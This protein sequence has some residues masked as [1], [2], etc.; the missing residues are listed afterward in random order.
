MLASGG[1][2]AGRRTFAAHLRG[3]GLGFAAG[4]AAGVA[5]F[6]LA[7]V[8]VLLGDQALT[9]GDG[10]LIVVGVNFAE[11]QE[12]MTV[13]AVID[14]CGLQRRFDANDFGEVDVAFDLLLCR[15][16]YIKFLKARSVQHHHASFLCVC[17]IDQHSLDHSK[18]YSVAPRT[19]RTSR[20]YV[21]RAWRGGKLKGIKGGSADGCPSADTGRTSH[22]S[23]ENPAKLRRAMANQA[24][25]SQPGAHQAAL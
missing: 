19:A 16:L 6:F 14:K 7:F 21:R 15:G 9:V 17:G 3:C 18:A 1:A 20:T 12:P 5:F 23:G 8:T 13:P 11:G 22:S 25:T 4:A 2:V 24:G 10:D